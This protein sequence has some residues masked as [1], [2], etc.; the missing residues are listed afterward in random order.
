MIFGY[1]KEFYDRYG[2]KIPIK[3]DLADYPHMLIAGASGSGK[4]FALLFLIGQLLQAYPDI[5]LFIC[6]FKKSEEFSFLNLYQHYYAGKDC[7]KGIMEY[8]RVFTEI[9]ETGQNKARY[10]L[11]TDE[12]PA[13]I[14]YLQMLDKMNKTK[15]ANEIL[16]AVSEILMLGR[17]IKFGVWIIVQRADST[18]FANG[19]RDNFMIVIGLGKLSKE[20]K[21][22]IFTGQDIPDCIM[23]KGE[24]ILLADGREMQTVKFPLIAD[25]KDW[26][27]HIE[28]ILQH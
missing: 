14:N 20:Q 5:I 26:K 10:L 4:S 28:L 11:I 23:G 22:M 16:G 15:C 18:L 24:G 25:V 12:Y 3:F 2:L 13:F 6:D 7:Y 8:Y 21:A 17:G 19:A 27:N 1:V 9:R